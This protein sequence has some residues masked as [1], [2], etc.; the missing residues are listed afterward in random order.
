MPPAA[1][2]PIST[3]GLSI[4]LSLSSRYKLH[5]LFYFVSLVQSSSPVDRR[6]WCPHLA[7]IACRRRRLGALIPSP[8]PLPVILPPVAPSSRRGALIPSPVAPSSHHRRHLLPFSHGRSGRLLHPAGLS[9]TRPHRLSVLSSWQIM[10]LKS[11]LKAKFKNQSR[12]NRNPV[13]KGNL[14]LDHCT[15]LGENI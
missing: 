1:L 9:I 11:Q 7:A 14:L 2:S 8:P 4:A 15:K 5:P 6:V 3:L 10:K 13:L 12:A